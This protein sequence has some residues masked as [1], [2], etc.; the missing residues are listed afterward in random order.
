MNRGWD[1]GYKGRADHMNVL[2]RHNRKK[3][4]DTHEYSYGR[5]RDNFARRLTYTAP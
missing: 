4:I 5:Q 2:H 1:L 3:I